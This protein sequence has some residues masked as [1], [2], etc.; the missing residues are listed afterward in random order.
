MSRGPS[1]CMVVERDRGRGGW[2]SH[3][4][5]R[6]RKEEGGWEGGDDGDNR[7]EVAWSLP[8]L[9]KGALLLFIFILSA[10]IS[11]SSL[12]EHTQNIYNR[13]SSTRTTIPPSSI[14]ICSVIDEADALRSD[15]LN[16]WRACQWWCFWCSYIADSSW[17]L[18]VV[19][20]YLLTV[21][22]CGAL[23]CGY[24]IFV[25]LLLRERERDVPACSL[26]LLHI[27]F[28]F[29]PYSSY[30][31]F[32]LLSIISRSNVSQRSGE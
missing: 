3:R 2:E 17:G 9:P 30:F 10:S 11:H 16:W 28:S 26:A 18:D 25:L 19:I 32:L 4:Q 15:H 12:W 13:Q 29:N 6:R 8:P 24:V 22:E 14:S 27:T 1:S 20:S 21:P 31:R 5:V 7:G 23:W